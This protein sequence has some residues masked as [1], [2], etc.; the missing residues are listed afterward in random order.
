MVMVHVMM[1][2]PEE[3]RRGHDFRP[4]R[5]RCSICNNSE[6]PDGEEQQNQGLDTRTNNKQTSTVDRSMSDVDQL[7][8]IFPGSSR[9]AGSEN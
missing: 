3:P 5:R 8:D 6:E 1:V 7:G 4:T 2:L 9:T